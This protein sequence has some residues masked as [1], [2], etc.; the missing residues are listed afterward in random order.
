MRK[1]EVGYPQIKRQLY[2]V[3][4]HRLSAEQGWHNHGQEDA[5][6]VDAALQQLLDREDALNGAALLDGQEHG[7]LT[8]FGLPLLLQRGATRVRTVAEGGGAGEGSSLRLSVEKLR[9][10]GGGGVWR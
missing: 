3:H 4:K 1:E 7:V 10:G 6:L 5:R 8:V 2:I 9:G